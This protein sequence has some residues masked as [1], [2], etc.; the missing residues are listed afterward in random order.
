MPRQRFHLDVLERVLLM[1]RELT[2]L[3]LSEA[4]VFQIP[5]RELGQAGFDLRIGER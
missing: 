1:L 5:L 2:H 3:L 4:N